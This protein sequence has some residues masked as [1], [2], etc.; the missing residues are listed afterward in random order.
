MNKFGSFSSYKLNYQKSEC[1]PINDL[2]LQ[3][4]QEAVPFH[5]THSG[6][7][8][9]GINITR[10]FTSLLGA[11]FTP[12]VN[13]MKADFQ[14]WSSL[15]LTIAERVQSVK[16]NVLTKY[17]YLFQCL[18]LF[19]TKYFFHSVNTFITSFIWKN[20]VP[21]V[22]KGLLQRGL[23][24]PSFIHYYWAANLQ[25]ILLRL[26]APDTDWCTLEA[27]SCHSS[28]LPALV[29]SSLP[30][31]WSRFTSNP[32][33][34]ST[35]RIWDQF[36]NHYKFTSPSPLSPICKNHLFPASSLNLTFTQGGQE[37]AFLF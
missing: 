15:P 7:K 28:S 2:A 18:P 20:K 21:R 3:I 27:H 29:Y 33:V 1:F 8:Y 9:L 25:K 14:R 16:M 31:K 24:L 32:L 5:L 34:L 6:F 12:L 35:L 19:L 23:A 30:T 22:N 4:K 26:R 13:Q 37:A 17:L 36:R 10:S 11:N